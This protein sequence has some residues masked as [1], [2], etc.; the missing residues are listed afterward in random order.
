MATGDKV[1]AGR[2][3]SGCS[4]PMRLT[5]G[6]QRLQ[7]LLLLRCV[8][9]IA[10]CSSSALGC[11]TP[12]RTVYCSS[13]SLCCRRHASTRQSDRR[14]TLRP[15]GDLTARPLHP[16]VHG[17]ILVPGHRATEPTEPRPSRVTQPR[18][19]RRL[20]LAPGAP[21]F[22]LVTCRHS[23]RL[24]TDRTPFT[25]HKLRALRR[26]AKLKGASLRTDPHVTAIMSAPSSVPVSPASSK[27]SRS[28]D[29]ALSATYAALVTPAA[30]TANT[31]AGSTPSLLPALNVAASPNGTQS[32][33]PTPYP[34]FLRPRREG[35]YTPTC[36]SWQQS[37]T[38][39]QPSSTTSGTT[40]SGP[41]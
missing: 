31:P 23:K 29:S 24:E 9:L 37:L 18:Q 6:L 1:T 41:R 14:A 36:G 32:P 34:A 11:Y 20:T 13:L 3:G 33:D 19:T 12:R 17:R 2:P 5:A 35:R 16:R 4:S 40:W 25:L 39:S 15:A 10:A 26:K 22:P 30:T 28:K 38:L 8:V 27:R 7:Q 21:P